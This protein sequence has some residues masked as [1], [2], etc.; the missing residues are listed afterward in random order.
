MQTRLTVTG[1][2]PPFML[3][4]AKSGSADLF[5]F[6]PAMDMTVSGTKTVNIIGITGDKCHLVNNCSCSKQ[7]I[8]SGH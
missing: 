2:T 1:M 4:A 5:S 7:S 8:Y 3:R 6:L